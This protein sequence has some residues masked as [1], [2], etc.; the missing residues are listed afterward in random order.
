MALGNIELTGAPAT[1]LTAPTAH[2]A[3]IMLALCRPPANGLFSPFLPARLDWKV[4]PSAA[5]P[6]RF[7]MAAPIGITPERLP[8][9]RQ[10]QPPEP[11]QPPAQIQAR[12]TPRR[13]PP[14][15]PTPLHPSP[16][17]VE[18]SASPTPSL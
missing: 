2:L 1:S 13:Q 9:F 7:I 15:L 17:P 11:G 14:R 12:Q 16:R 6:L 18:R 3:A 10:M 8:R 5:W 4:P